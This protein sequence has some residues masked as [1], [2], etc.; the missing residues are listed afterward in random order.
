MPK[1]RATP[2]S[3]KRAKK[4]EQVR[5]I[6]RVPNFMKFYATNVH[7]GLTTQD[8][9]FELLNEKVEDESGW[10]FISDALVILSPTAAKKLFNILKECIKVY[11]EEHGVIPT[12]FS[13]E[14]TY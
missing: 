5:D 2:K 3:K 4:T 7:G 1:K 6:F 13:D 9:R 14:K 11:E 8:F 10:H 12:E